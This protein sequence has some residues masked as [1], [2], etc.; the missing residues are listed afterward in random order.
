M[1]YKLECYLAL[2]AVVEKLDANADM[3]VDGVRDCMDE[4]WYS[5]DEADHKALDEREQESE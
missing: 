3:A 2:E 4:L 5:L 1:S